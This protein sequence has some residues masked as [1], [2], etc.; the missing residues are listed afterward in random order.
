MYLSYFSIAELFP[1][2]EVLMITILLGATGGALSTIV[3]RRRHVG[4]IIAIIIGMLC[5]YSTG[6]FI[7]TIFPFITNKA[8]NE[9][10]STIFIAMAVTLII[11]LI[12]GSNKGR[13][14][15]L[16]RA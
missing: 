11:H 5:G 10:C 9:I 3:M 4:Y 16:W 6:A 14:R 7:G 8:A 2:W 1:H 15:T 12:F 13:D